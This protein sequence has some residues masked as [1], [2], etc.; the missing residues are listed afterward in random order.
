MNAAARLH[1]RNIYCIIYSVPWFR[2][3]TYKLPA[4]L[5]PMHTLSCLPFKAVACSCHCFQLH[6]SR[7]WDA[8]LGHCLWYV[9]MTDPNCLKGLLQSA[10]C[11][12]EDVHS[13][14]S[15]QY[16]DGFIATSD[17]STRNKLPSDGRPNQRPSPAVKTDAWRIVSIEDSNKTAARPATRTENRWV[18][19]SSLPEGLSGK[20]WMTLLI[21]HVVNFLTWATKACGVHSW[22]CVF[23]C[24]VLPERW[25][26]MGDGCEFATQHHK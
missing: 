2:E 17:Y 1:Q 6:F 5:F 4:M 19:S 18:L 11:Q 7:P 26:C 16:S 23:C 14:V 9:A 21:L 22:P 25:G 24:T 20:V 8:L 3:N 13:S 15:G 12:L 10:Q